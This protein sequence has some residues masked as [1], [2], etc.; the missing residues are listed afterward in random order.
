[1]ICGTIAGLRAGE[2]IK[3]FDLFH[4]LMLPSGNDAACVLSSFFGSLESTSIRL[5]KL[6]PLPKVIAD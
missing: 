4:A 2:H 5:K 3:L 6:A 1:M